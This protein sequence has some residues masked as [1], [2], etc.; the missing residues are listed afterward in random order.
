MGRAFARV[1]MQ[2]Q[3]VS[4]GISPSGL[5]AFMGFSLKKNITWTPRAAALT[6]TLTQ[7]A[8]RVLIKKNVT[9]S[10]LH[11]LLA[12]AHYRNWFSFFFFGRVLPLDLMN[13]LLFHKI[14]DTRKSGSR[15]WE[16][17]C[18]CIRRRGWAADDHKLSD[19][20]VTEPKK[21]T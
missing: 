5:R 19:P 16:K 13:W 1:C 21:I 7:P 15:I 12:R 20:V 6:V 18:C 8:H 17:P 9:I 2:N 3:A 10:S 14:L 11:T 4:L